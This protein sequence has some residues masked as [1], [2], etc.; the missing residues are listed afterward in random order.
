MSTFD[1]FVSGSSDLFLTR[2]LQHANSTSEFPQ[3]RI[4]QFRPLSDRPPPLA[5]FLSHVHSD[6]LAGLDTLKAPFVYCSPTTRE[7]LLRLEKFPHRMNFTKNILECR[8]QTYKHLQRVLKPIPLET[9]TTIELSPGN[10]IC[11]TLFDANHCSG[12]VMFLIEGQGKAALYTGDIRS[13]EW[14][15]NNLV[16]HPKVIPYSS[17]QR[18]LD[19]IYLDTT[20]ATKIDRYLHFPSKFDGLRE[21]LEKIQG[22]PEDT[23]FHM[24]SWTF[25]MALYCTSHV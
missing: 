11:V 7:L 25:G 20:F 2:S 4:D 1:G 22:Y 19:T 15:V 24:N 16:R 21:L 12:A 23:I 6:H 17:G 18:H 13:E 3:I 8:K 5:C 9:P 10:S 14:W